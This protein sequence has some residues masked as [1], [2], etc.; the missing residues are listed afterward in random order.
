MWRSIKEFNTSAREP[1]GHRAGCWR[2]PTKVR[3]PTVCEKI[4]GLRNSEREYQK[5]NDSSI[6]DEMSLPLFHLE[7]KEKQPSTRGVT[8]ARGM[9]R[10]YLGQITYLPNQL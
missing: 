5:L 8:T 2:W 7:V 4:Q 1:A 6:S 9:V 3:G 10:G